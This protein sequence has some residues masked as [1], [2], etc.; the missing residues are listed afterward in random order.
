MSN[1]RKARRPQPRRISIDQL[2]ALLSN[3][4]GLLLLEY[5]HEDGCPTIRSQ[6]S[7]DCTCGDAVEVT[8]RAPFGLQPRG[9]R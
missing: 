3:S 1:R 7:D 9:Q 2:A 4:A 8:A 6:R 5:R